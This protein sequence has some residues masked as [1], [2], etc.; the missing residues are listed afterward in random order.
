MQLSKLFRNSVWMLAL[1]LY[2]QT[3]PPPA[4]E[5]PK[6]AP[7]TEAKGMVPRGSP[8]DYQAHIQVGKLTIGAEFMR[9]A[10]PTP[11]G[12]L[13]TEDYVVVETGLFGAP[14]A[15]STIS[16]GD[17]AMRINGKKAVPGVPYGLVLESTKDPDWVPPELPSEKKGGSGLSTGGGGDQGSA[18]PPPPKMP[19]PLVRAMHLKVQ[20]AALPEGDRP[21]P[22]AGLLFFSFRGKS[23]SIK[24]VE[25]IY[26]GPAGKITLTLQ[27]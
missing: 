11:Q 7:G 24:S 3:P 26:T 6:E 22:Q 25:L 13:T 27:P 17:F 18:P 16:A 19:L 1:G 23:T 10:I 15:R 2:A 12:E 4:Q 20:K 9:H 8:N 21:L 5:P 14:G